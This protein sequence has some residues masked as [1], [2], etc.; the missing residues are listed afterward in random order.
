MNTAIRKTSDVAA[1]HAQIDAPNLRVSH[2][3]GLD[4]GAADV[5]GHGR[6]VRNF[7]FAHAAGT[8]LAEA[9][10]VERARGVHFTNYGTDF[11]CADFQSDYDRIRIKHFYVW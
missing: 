2:L 6:S 9:H 1:G 4:D 3:L 7:A 5:L 10:D 11:G 8:R